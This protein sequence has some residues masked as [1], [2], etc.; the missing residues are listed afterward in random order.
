M[1]PLDAWDRVNVTVLVGGMLL[2]GLICV[3]SSADAAISCDTETAN[4][5]LSM[6]WTQDG[7]EDVSAWVLWWRYTGGSEWRVG[8]I[9]SSR[10]RLNYAFDPPRPER[11]VHAAVDPEPLAGPPY[12]VNTFSPVMRSLPVCSN[13]IDCPMPGRLIDLAVTARNASGDGG[14]PP[15]VPGI[16]PTTC[17]VPGGPALYVSSVC[18]ACIWQGPPFDLSTRPACAG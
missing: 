16:V 7:I 3:G 4:P 8:G 11:L 13:P 15:T 18:V 6:C 14:D 5:R 17:G 9:M 12:L 10:E 2:L 1:R